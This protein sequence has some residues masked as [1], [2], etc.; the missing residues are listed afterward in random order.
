MACAWNGN[1]VPIMGINSKKIWCKSFRDKPTVAS[2]GITTTT[3][4]TTTKLR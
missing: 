1:G 2:I 4:K 3:K